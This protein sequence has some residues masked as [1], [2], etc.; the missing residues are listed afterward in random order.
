MKTAK[1]SD[2][3]RGWFIGDFEPSVMRTP[4]FEVGILSHKKGEVWPAHYHKVA[5]E[6]NVLLDG[7]MRIAGEIVE[8]GDIFWFE[9]GDIADPEFLEDCRVCVVKR[10]SIIGDKYE[11]LSK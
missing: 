5:T 8:V 3:T 4:L 2:M 7:R 6:Y 1:L 11:V 10:P 9:P